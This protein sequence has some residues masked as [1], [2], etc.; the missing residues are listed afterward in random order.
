ML[1]CSVTAAEASDV[2]LAWLPVSGAAGYRTYLRQAAQPYG[3]GSDVGYIP[4]DADGIVRCVVH[5][6][7]P[8]VANYFSVTSYDA[9]GVES[10]RSN[11][12]VLMVCSAAPM[13]GCRAPTKAGAAVLSVRGAING[14]PD[15]LDWKWKNGGTVT[16]QD[17]GDPVTATSYMLCIYD[18]SRGAAALVTNAGLQAGGVCGEERACWRDRGRGGFSYV[19]RLPTGGFRKVK[20]HPGQGG[21]SSIQV[22]AKGGILTFPDAAGSSLFQQDPAVTVQL[23]NDASP[24]VCWEAMYSA[25]ARVNTPTRFKDTSD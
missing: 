19:N 15:R 21:K 24:S 12:L 17:L 4:A 14:K 2:R 18:D 5:G 20:L 11:E 1:L 22:S 6:V 13:A 8:G 10:P 7:A 23:V 25:A 16:T 3:P 9:D